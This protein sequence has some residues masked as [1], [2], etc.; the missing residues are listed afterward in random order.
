MPKKSAPTP[1]VVKN[2]SIS[3]SA[4][5]DSTPN[6]LDLTDAGMPDAEILNAEILNAD[7]PRSSHKRNYNREPGEPNEA[8]ERAARRKTNFQ[9]EINAMN[10]E[11]DQ[12][13]QRAKGSLNTVE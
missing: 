13:L 10:R 9:R 6:D 8:D 7:A 1:K 4:A 12:M 5:M 3:N 2:N 11:Y